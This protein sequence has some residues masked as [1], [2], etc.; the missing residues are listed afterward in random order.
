V[1]GVELATQ[2]THRALA[3][4]AVLNGQ[5]YR[6]T[7]EEL[8]AYAEQPERRPARYESPIWAGIANMASMF[9]RLHT[10]ADPEE[11]FTEQLFRLHWAVAA[12]GRIIVTPLGQAMLRALEQQSVDAGS[13]LDV[14]LR[15]DDP[16]ALARAIDRIAQA[17]P[18]MLVEPYFRLDVL[19]PVVHAT[20]VSRVLTSE[21][22]SSKARAALKLGVESIVLERDFEVRVAPRELHDRWV[23]SES[24]AV[25]FIGSS[26]NSLGAVST[27]MGHVSDAAGD[28]RRLCEGLWEDAEHLASAQKAGSPPSMQ[29]SSTDGSMAEAPDIH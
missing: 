11:S 5:G 21:R 18:A 6:P 26:L 12:N 10:M 22:I 23:I 27:A 20:E 14:V 9:A 17:G 1:P 13:V 7:S 28:I 25:Q 4:L 29:V 15:P 2:E 19:L 3:Y 16:T 24:G 8:E